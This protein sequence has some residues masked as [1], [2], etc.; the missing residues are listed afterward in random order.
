M[1]VIDTTKSVVTI[2]GVEVELGKEIKI[3]QETGQTIDCDPEGMF[4][5]GWIKD[6]KTKQGMPT[7]WY[8]DGRFVGAEKGGPNDLMNADLMNAETK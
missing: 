3:D 5:H 1:S 7:I 8:H 2:S 6:G 4:V